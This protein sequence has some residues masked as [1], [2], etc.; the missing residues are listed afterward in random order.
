MLQYHILYNILQFYPRDPKILTNL[1][2]VSKNIYD[3][4]RRDECKILWSWLSN[5]ISYPSKPPK[6]WIKAANV[7]SGSGIGVQCTTYKINTEH[8]CDNKD[9]ITLHNVIDIQY[10]NVGDIVHIIG[11]GRECIHSLHNTYMI[12][13]SKV[14]RDINIHMYNYLIGPNISTVVSTDGYIDTILQLI[15]NEFTENIYEPSSMNDVLT[16]DETSPINYNHAKI[17]NRTLMLHNVSCLDYMLRYNILDVNMLNDESIWVHVFKRWNEGDICSMFSYLVDNIHV[18]H[19]PPLSIIMQHIP[20]TTNTY[21]ISHTDIQSK[22]EYILEHVL[23]RNGIIDLSNK[24]PYSSH[25]Y[26][27]KCSYYKNVLTKYNIDYDNICKSINTTDH[28][29]FIRLYLDKQY[30]ICQWMIDNIYNF[31]TEY[32]YQLILDDDI[33]YATKSIIQELLSI[34]YATNIEDYLD[35]LYRDGDLYYVRWIIDNDI[36]ALYV[37]DCITDVITYNI[38]MEKTNI[39]IDVPLYNE[40]IQYM[41]QCLSNIVV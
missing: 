5:G 13:N 32:N 18:S 31:G 4:V 40:F 12:H 23:D 22:L 25:K 24:I 26:L 37:G 39:K 35:M 21:M 30:D 11:D 17:L 19:L 1:M 6:D 41:R 8:T 38:V 33:F 15:S 27:I 36:M 10:P 34:D 29:D 2:L 16:Y 7:F 28:K 20:T 9:T 3:N 14:Y